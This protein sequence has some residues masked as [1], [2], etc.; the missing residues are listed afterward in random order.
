MRRF[1]AL[2]I[3]IAVATFSGVGD[4]QGAQLNVS[5]YND[6]GVAPPML[7]KAEFVA[8]TVLARAGIHV[9]WEKCSAPGTSAYSCDHPDIGRQLSV[10]ITPTTIHSMQAS[11]FGVAFLSLEGKGRYADVFY[12][13]VLQLHDDN[14]TSLPDVLGCVMAHELGHLLLGSNAH[15]TAGIMQRQWQAAE[16]NQLQ[17]GALLFTHEQAIKMQQRLSGISETQELVAG[18]SLGSY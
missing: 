17:K 14:K 8:A 3:F 4:A 16:L 18:R 13:R 7:N 11:I 9:T 1:N 6:A 2:F 15:S 5:V 12:S 10:R